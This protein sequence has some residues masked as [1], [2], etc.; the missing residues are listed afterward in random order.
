MSL[1]QYGFVQNAL[2]AGLLLSIASGIIGS[3]IVVKR[4][5][6]LIGGISH[7]S[8]GGL[9]LFYYLGLNPLLGAFSVALLSGAVI[10]L[11]SEK[12]L[13]AHNA[14]ISVIWAFGMAIGIIF[15][16]I[17]PGFA[18]NL[19]TYLFGD[20]LTVS[21]VD[22]LYIAIYDA[23]LLL[24]IFLFFKPLLVYLFDKEFAALHGIRVGLY[25]LFFYLFISVAIVMMIRSVGIILVLAL[26]TIPPLIAMPFCKRFPCI[27]AAAVVLC[28]L[29]FVGGFFIAYYSNLP[30]G[31]IIIVLGTFLLFLS[32]AI[33]AVR[34]KNS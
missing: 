26:L 24:M 1:L 23:L 15:I 30:T 29:I 22:I 7:A 32:K 17:T 19:L 10:G 5:T 33:C 31:P 11:S 20:I 9:G 4:D 12:K 6:L 27:M 21:N 13:H 3:L 2:L 25:R 28:L 8:F 14:L 16:T 34:K 18:P